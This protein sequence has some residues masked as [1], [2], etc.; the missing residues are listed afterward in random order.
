MKSLN[1]LMQEVIQLSGNIET[2]Y[3]ELYKYLGETPVKIGDSDKK[4][5]TTE[6]LMLY[7]ETLKSLLKHHIETHK[8]SED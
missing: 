2:N 3:P 6:D 8:L 1:Q 4:E 7:L 5:I